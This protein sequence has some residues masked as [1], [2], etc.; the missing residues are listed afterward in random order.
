VG[1]V[2]FTTLYSF[3]G[4]VPTGLALIQGNLYGVA[5]LGGCGNVFELEAP[6]TVGEPW[7]LS[8]LYTFTGSPGGVGDACDPGGPPVRGANGAL[9]G[10][11]AAGGANGNGAMYELQPPASPGVAWTEGVAYSF[12]EIYD[13]A[14]GPAASLLVNGSDGSFYVMCEYANGSLL[15][16]LPPAVPGLTWTGALL[17]EV[18]DTVDSLVAGPNGSLYGTSAFGEGGTGSVFKLLPP[19]APGG[20]WSEIVLHSFVLGGASDPVTPT[21]A[22][23]GT[24]YGTTYGT[25]PGWYMGKSVAYSLTPPTSSGQA[26]TYTALRP[27]FSEQANTQLV[28]HNGNL[29]GT[30]ATLEGGTVFELEPPAAPGGAWTTTYLHQFSNGQVPFGQLIVDGSGTIFG[31]SGTMNTL[32]PS[33]GTIYKIEIQ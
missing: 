19:E 23:D 6:T 21:L 25:V 18:G 15:Q 22:S 16:L 10:L 31:M 2:R 24:I 8:T 29:Y 14:G 5:A 17:L 20:V 9:Y 13:Y 26:W 27:F 12:N 3:T 1:Q 30:L 32:N 11:A 28:L 7:T 33:A 4:G